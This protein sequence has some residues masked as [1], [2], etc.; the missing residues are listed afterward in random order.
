M[1]LIFSGSAHLAAIDEFLLGASSLSSAGPA[2]AL[3]YGS[4]CHS[5]FLEPCGCGRRHLQ[6]RR[7]AT[8]GQVACGV[9][10]SGTERKFQTVVIHLK[11]H[12]SRV[13]AIKCQL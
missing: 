10:G 8:V 1:R 9:A 11:Y 2:F 6:S 7:L 5:W 13:E 12:P 3:F 4:L